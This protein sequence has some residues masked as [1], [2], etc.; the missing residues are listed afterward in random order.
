MNNAK[1]YKIAKLLKIPSA[2]TQETKLKRFFLLEVIL[3]FIG[4]KKSLKVI[5][6]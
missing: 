6:G 5:I 2:N 4:L 3:N 1:I